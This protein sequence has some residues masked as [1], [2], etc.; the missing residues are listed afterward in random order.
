MTRR[1]LYIIFAVSL[2]LAVACN[3]YIDSKYPTNSPPDVGTAPTN[4]HVFLDNDAVRL[5]WTVA[6]SS[7]FSQYRVY[8]STTDTI[9]TELLDSSTTTEITLTNLKINT[10][11]AF[12]IVP[13][14]LSGLEGRGSG[15]VVARV[16]HMSITINGGARYTRSRTVQ[17]QF[18]APTGAS[19]VILSEDSTFPDANYQGYNTTVSF[20]LSDGDGNKIVYSRIQ[21]SDGVESLSLLSDSITLDTR[22]NIDSVYFSPTGTTFTP[23]DTI[24]FGLDAGETGGQARASFSGTSGV[25][26]YDDGDAPDG[27]A[28][29]G[30]YTGWYIVPINANLLDG[31]VTGSFT[32]EAGNNAP[33]ALASPLLNINTPP[34]PVQLVGYLDG[35]SARFNWT[36]T[37]DADFEAYR[38][39]RSSSSTVDTSSTMIDYEPGTGGTSFAYRV[40]AGNSYYFR[41]FV[42]DRHGAFAGSNTVRISN[43]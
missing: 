38:L 4:V 21:F 22:A 25:S 3:R 15:A 26:L 9:P 18:T 5:T 16:A 43:P 1:F 17:I 11:Y 14:L 33:S 8:S 28:N 37:N 30:V 32:D 23:G 31:T 34:S 2:L 12:R 41:V 39:Y 7:M 10:V 19:D 36:T 6:D 29:D 42:F 13:V 24:T 40:G 27:V 20:A 35:D